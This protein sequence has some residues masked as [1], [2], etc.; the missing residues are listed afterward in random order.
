MK[1]AKIAILHDATLLIT[2]NVAIN[3]Q[4]D[5]C[6][7][8]A[9]LPL[10]DSGCCTVCQQGTSCTVTNRVEST[11]GNL[12]LIQQRIALFYSQLVRGE[13]SPASI[14]EQKFA[15]TVMLLEMGT[16]QCLKLL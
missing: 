4:R 15:L 6:I 2:D 12:Q 9:K 1:R 13:C 11:A 8:V 3:P 14:Y 7:T 5:P 16:Q 10:T